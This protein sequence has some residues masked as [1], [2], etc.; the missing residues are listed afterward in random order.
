[1]FGSCPVNKKWKDFWFHTFF[2]MWC[3]I[4]FNIKSN[5]L[6]PILF[7]HTLISDTS[8]TRSTHSL[9]WESRCLFLIDHISE[10]NFGS[11]QQSSGCLNSFTDVFSLSMLTCFLLPILLKQ[12]V[13]HWKLDLSLQ[14]FAAFFFSSSVYLSSMHGGKNKNSK[15]QIKCQ[16]NYTSF[17]C[18][19][20]SLY[21]R[22][23]F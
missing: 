18:G 16:K 23:V 13:P 8:F 10:L 11:E 22:Y 12:E 7:I 21:Y 19:K 3:I 2:L 17:I 6:S 5:K 15:V 20:L 14:V 9:N 4:V 1:M